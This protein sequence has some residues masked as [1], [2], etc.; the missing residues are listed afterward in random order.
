ML[1]CDNSPARYLAAPTALMCLLLAQGLAPGAKAQSIDTYIMV[2]LP[3]STNV[4]EAD[5]TY[6]SSNGFHYTNG[7]TLPSTSNDNYGAGLRYTRYMAIGDHPIAFQISQSATYFADWQSGGYNEKNYPGMHTVSASNTNLSMLFWP[8][9]NAAEQAYVFTAAYLIP[10]DGSY[11]P[12]K[13]SAAYGGWQGDAQIGMSKGFGPNF[14]LQAAIDADFHGDE[15][16]G[17]GTRLAIDPTYRLQIWANWDWSN[18]LRTSV[19]YTGVVGGAENPYSTVNGPIPLDYTLLNAERQNLRAAVS[20]WWT[21]HLM[22]SLE[23]SGTVQAD[24]GYTNTIGTEA[25]VKFLF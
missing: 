25:K 20:Y 15:S 8:Y 10:P 21:A 9:A 17:G 19:G 2:P 23:V 1:R 16:L 24:S 3:A 12:N 5:G 14:S 7:Q 11:A 22:T 6:N 4:I 18:G 13:V